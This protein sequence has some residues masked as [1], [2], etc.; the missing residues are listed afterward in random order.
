VFKSRL[1]KW[2]ER[3]GQI[4]SWAFA[5]ILLLL[6][7]DAIREVTKYGSADMAME[8][9]LHSAN[10]D[11]VIHMRLFRGQ[12]NLYISGF[13]LFLW[14][15]IRRL[16]DLISKE[17]QLEASSEAAMKQ[18]Q[19]ASAA[20]KTLME[21]G[22]GKGGEGSKEMEQMKEKV[23]AL[24]KELKKVEQDR[25]TLKKQSEGLHEEYNRLADKVTKVD[26]KSDK[27]AD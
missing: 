12:R 25:D 26:K 3:Y 19:G 23:Q 8:Q 5:G 7:M 27:K 13:A 24:Q 21:K 11:A 17:A 22:N 9:Q 14:L 15:V 2:V 16:V 6:F 20:A 18:A 10:A 4:Y 1:L